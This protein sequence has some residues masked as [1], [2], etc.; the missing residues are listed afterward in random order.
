MNI[1][2]RNGISL[3]SRQYAGVFAEVIRETGTRYYV[4]PPFAGYA[5]GGH[6]SLYVDKADVIATNA[7]PEMWEAIKEADWKY[8]QERTHMEQMI[9][10]EHK[11]AVERIIQGT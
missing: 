8:A 9:R 5:K 2:A 4:K 1:I 3:Y 11:A 10:D 7:T 6:D